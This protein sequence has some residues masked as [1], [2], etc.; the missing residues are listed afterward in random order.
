MLLGSVTY[1]VTIMQILSSDFQD[2][3]VAFFVVYTLPDRKVATMSA[4]HSHW[5]R[6]AGWWRQRKGLE[7]SGWS[8]WIWLVEAEEMS[9]WSKGSL[10]RSD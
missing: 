7:R 2:W 6:V 3:H 10:K 8:G 9:G 1:D 4:A 5:S